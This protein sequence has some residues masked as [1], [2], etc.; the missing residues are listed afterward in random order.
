TAKILCCRH[1][2]AFSPLDSEAGTF[3]GR[4]RIIE[5]DLLQRSLSKKRSYVLINGE[6]LETWMLKLACGLFYSKIAAKDGT[7]LIDDHTLD[8][9]LVQEA[10]FFGLWRDGCG[11]YMKPPQG[12][13]IPDADTVSMTPL[14]ALNENRVVGAGLIVTG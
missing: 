8:E 1:N 5:A 3:F 13:R 14:I 7:K 12:F 2:S 4:L 11:L 6:M 10:L 9:Q